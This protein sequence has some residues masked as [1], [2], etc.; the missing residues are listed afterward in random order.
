[1][2]AQKNRKLRIEKIGKIGNFVLKNRRIIGKSI[3]VSSAKIASL[4][5]IRV[6]TKAMNPR[7]LCLRD[8]AQLTRLRRSENDQWRLAYWLS[9]PASRMVCLTTGRA[10]FYDR[11]W[12]HANQAKQIFGKL[13]RSSEDRVKFDMIALSLKDIEPGLKSPMESFPSINLQLVV[14]WEYVCLSQNTA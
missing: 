14:G 8:L 11:R 12:S 6:I 4:H 1:M 3:V 2:V 10:W 5:P 7:L 13:W 9:Y